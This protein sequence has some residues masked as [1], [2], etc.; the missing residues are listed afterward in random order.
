MEQDDVW[1][2]EEEEFNQVNLGDTISETNRGRIDK[3]LS[4]NIWGEKK[5]KI[6]IV[7]FYSWKISSHFCSNKLV[8]K[9]SD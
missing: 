8:C 4:R 9:Y 1:K 6:K 7:S 3:N 5:M 2:V